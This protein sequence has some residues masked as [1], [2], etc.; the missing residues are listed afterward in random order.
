MTTLLEKITGDFAVLFDKESGLAEEVECQRDD[1]FPWPI[2]VIFQVVSEAD[3]IQENVYGDSCFILIHEADLHDHFDRKPLKNDK[4]TRLLPL[5]EGQIERKE[6][7]H[8]IGESQRIANG[9]WKC[10]AQKNIRLYP[11]FPEY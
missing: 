9:V 8:L 3:Q 7:W 2:S 10:L 1:G 5:A 11:E 4:I 6:I